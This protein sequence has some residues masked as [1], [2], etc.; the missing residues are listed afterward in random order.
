MKS[1][2]SFFFLFFFAVTITAQKD[3]TTLLQFESESIDLGMITKGELVKSKFSFKNISSQEVTIEF[4]S[5]CECTDAEWPTRTF[6]PGEQG[7]IPFTFDSNKKDVAEA[8]DVDIILKNQ[9]QAGNP[10]FYYLQYT[11][12]FKS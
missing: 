4:V 6:L 7:E 5:T 11:F 8:V 9:D 10:V 3:Q 2:L 1:T 12:E